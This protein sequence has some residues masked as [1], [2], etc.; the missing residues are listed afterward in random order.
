M[1]RCPSRWPHSAAEMW[2][3]VQEHLSSHREPPRGLRSR[4]PR[5]VNN[6]QARRQCFLRRSRTLHTAAASLGIMTGYP[7]IY[8]VFDK[9]RK[10]VIVRGSLPQGGM[11]IKEE[12]VRVL[13]SAV[14]PGARAAKVVSDVKID[15]TPDRVFEVC[16]AWRPTPA[17]RCSRS[18]GSRS[19]VASR[20]IRG[21]TTRSSSLLGL[22]R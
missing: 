13:H 22:P 16:S 18:R 3:A 5:F 21:R 20:I 15:V 1:R 9:D 4:P 8:A 11:V 2:D 17:D 14:R 19:L 7:W 6:R 12:I 10:Q